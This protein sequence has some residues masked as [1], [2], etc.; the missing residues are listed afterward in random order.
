MEIIMTKEV[1]QT[2][3]GAEFKTEFKEGWSHLSLQIREDNES[4]IHD[5][6]LTPAQVHALIEVL[7]EAVK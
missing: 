6:D 7:Q 3:E 2:W 4:S 1:K 5:I